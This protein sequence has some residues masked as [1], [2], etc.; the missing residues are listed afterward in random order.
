LLNDNILII[1]GGLSKYDD[2]TIKEINELKRPL[3]LNKDRAE[4]IFYSILWSDP[5]DENLKSPYWIKSK[6]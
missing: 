2:L 1:H 4:E 3:D 5:K 6:R